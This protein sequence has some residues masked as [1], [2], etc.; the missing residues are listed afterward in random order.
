MYQQ[1]GTNLAI[2]QPPV[3]A[4]SNG[5]VLPRHLKRPGPELKIRGLEI[6]MVLL[7]Q[8]GRRVLYQMQ[9]VELLMLIWRRGSQASR[10]KK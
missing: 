8:M 9:I 5:N 6:I 4:L 10:H 1:N 7:V 2:N 3:A